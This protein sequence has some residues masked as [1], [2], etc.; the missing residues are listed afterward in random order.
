[1]QNDEL[2]LR[3][4]QLDSAKTRARLARALRGAVELADRQPD[5]RRTPPIRRSDIRAN[6]E[7]LLELAECLRVSRPLGGKG[8]A[9]TSQLIHDPPSPLYHEDASRSLKVIAFEA[10]IALE[11]DHPAV[12]E[13]EDEAIT[14]LRGRSAK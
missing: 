5:T 1:M 8:L 10:L 6:R 12:P 4:G 3:L 2:S 14:Q 7:L 11:R 13:A 9:M